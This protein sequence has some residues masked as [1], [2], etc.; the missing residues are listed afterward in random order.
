MPVIDLRVA[1]S[2]GWLAGRL[3]LTLDYVGASGGGTTFGSWQTSLAVHSFQAGALY[4]YPVVGPLRVFGR[5]AALLDADHLNLSA[6]D[7]A[8]QLGQ[9]A[10]TAGALAGAGA[11]VV[12]SPSPSWQLGLVV[13]VGYALRFNEAR[14]DRVQP[15][16]DSGTSPAPVPFT[17][18]DLG[19][20]SLSGLQWRLGASVHFL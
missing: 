6:G 13:E 2:P 11:E 10:A 12:A 16:V 5:A 17:P 9:W 19:S 15:S 14:F 8:L 1:Y 3:A 7:N 4:R 20:L 18:V